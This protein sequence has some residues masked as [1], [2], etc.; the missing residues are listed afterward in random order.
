MYVHGTSGK[1]IL[2]GSEWDDN[3]L[4]GYE[5][6]DILHGGEADDW[7]YGDEG[8]DVLYGWGG[9]NSIDGGL[10]ADLLYGGDWVDFYFVDDPDDQVFEEE[11]GL[12]TDSDWVYA[13]ISA[14]LGAYANVEHLTLEGSA[15]LYG[16]GT[17][18]DNSIN[19][20]AGANLILGG[21]GADRIGGEAGNDALFGESG[22]DYILGGNGVD[23]LVGGTGLDTLDGGQGSDA[24]YGEDGHDVLQGGNGFYTDILVGGGGD[25]YLDG[26]FQ[27]LGDYD[28][29]YGGAGNDRFVVDTPADLVFEQSGEGVDTVYAVIDGAGFYLYENIENLT[30]WGDDTPFGV[31]NGLDNVLIGG[32]T[33]NWLLG[34]AGN[35]TLYGDYGNDVLFG[36]AGADTFVIDYDGSTDVIG[37]FQ[38]GSDK[39]QLVDSYD[40]FSQLTGRIYQDGAVGAIYLPDGSAVILHNVVVANLTAADFIFL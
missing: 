33:D 16:V 38:Q 22:D 30:I 1:D 11:F 12:R 26:G 15:D 3:T 13:S 25:D 18:A 4:Y 27:A 36:E 20:N 37:D 17:D 40:T 31:G 35:D 6:D 10:G 9:L 21:A 32:F 5:D 24:L 8:N 29:L 39:I 14:Y 23:Y 2:Y 19:G 28:L 7:L 34:G